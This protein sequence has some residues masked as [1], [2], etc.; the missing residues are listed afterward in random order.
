MKKL[1]WR[2][3]NRRS[4][5]VPADR[6]KL[7][8]TSSDTNWATNWQDP[9][10]KLQIGTSNACWVPLREAFSL[11]VSQYLLQCQ[12]FSSIQFQPTVCLMQFT[13][14]IHRK[15]TSPH[16]ETYHSV[17]SA[18]S[19]RLIHAIFALTE[20]AQIVACANGGCPALLNNL[21]EC[22]RKFM[23]NWVLKFA[24]VAFR[25]S[26]GQRRRRPSV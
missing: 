11:D 6:H 1:R 25:Q 9:G 14:E 21:Q 18:R 24:I 7:R 22:T 26:L 19:A 17:H 8:D 16:T 4:R 20:F 10:G 13:P 23:Q 15:F 12:P 3:Q 2:S 5:D